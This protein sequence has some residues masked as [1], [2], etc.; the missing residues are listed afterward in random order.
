MLLL[1]FILV[2]NVFGP[3]IRIPSMGEGATE[4][5]AELV[6]ETLLLKASTYL[7]LAPRR[8]P[9]RNCGADPAE[10]KGL[11]TNGGGGGSTRAMI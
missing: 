1:L 4:L 2:L 5:A 7:F 8:L 6:A 11:G 10:I 3:G 9:R